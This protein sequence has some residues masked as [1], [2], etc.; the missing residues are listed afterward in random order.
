MGY[1]KSPQMIN[2][3]P[4]IYP[5]IYP[6]SIMQASRNSSDTLD[7]SGEFW[8]CPAKSSQIAGQNVQQGKNEPLFVS[9][10]ELKNVRWEPEMSGEEP[11]VRRTFCPAS[12]KKF[13]GS[14]LRN[15]CNWHT[16]IFFPLT[17]GQLENDCLLGFRMTHTIL[18]VGEFVNLP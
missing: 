17:A 6:C 12:H 15:R 3:R 18:F 5:L 4:L 9:H 13:S 14:L 8:K 2:G 10:S 1:N 16:S 11:Q 7:M